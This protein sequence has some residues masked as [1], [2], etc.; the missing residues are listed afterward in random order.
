MVKRAAIHAID[1]LINALWTIRARIA[2]DDTVRL[3][4]R[5]DAAMHALAREHRREGD[6]A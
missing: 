6:A 5:L 4:N 1:W 3:L 2:P